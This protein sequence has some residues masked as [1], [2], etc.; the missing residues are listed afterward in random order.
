MQMIDIA[1]ADRPYVGA[2]FRSPVHPL[3][4]IAHMGAALAASNVARGGIQFV[5]SLVV[6]RFLGRDG[7]GIWTLAAAVASALTAAFDLGFGVL[8]T[9]EAAR[10]EGRI[11]RLLVD[12]LVARFALFVPVAVLAYSGLLTS[13]TGVVHAD[14]LHAAV[15]LAAA[16][17]TYGT[18]APA[19]RAAP[20]PLVSIL[21][22]ETIGAL[23]QC[24]GVAL[25]LFR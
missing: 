9:R 21:A 6:A 7:F 8:L 1:A 14:T 23:L 12:A 24:G 10:A 11:G 17:L 16:G 20:R 22:I 13:W 4:R 3:G 25:L 19:C 5:T 18:F 15:F 2:I